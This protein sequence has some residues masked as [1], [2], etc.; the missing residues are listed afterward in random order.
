MESPTRG[1]VSDCPPKCDTCLSG[2]CRCLVLKV[3]GQVG[4]VSQTGHLQR[5][6]PC[7]GSRTLQRSRLI[8]VFA[9]E[10]LFCRNPHQPPSTPA[11]MPGTQT[12]PFPVCVHLRSQTVPPK[13][14]T[15]PRHPLLPQPKP[16]QVRFT[17][18]CSA[19]HSQ[20]SRTEL[21]RLTLCSASLSWRLWRWPS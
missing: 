7:R 5:T 15:V 17:T 2:G 3:S 12:F 6:E 1:R 9:H 8:N 16:Q 20:T 13:T 18:R 21:R 14:S 11:N 4:H 10:D 19:H